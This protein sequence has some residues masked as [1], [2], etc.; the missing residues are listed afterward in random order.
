MGSLLRSV[1]GV[2]W[3]ELRDATGAAADG[4]PLLLSRIAYGDEDTARIAIDGLGDAI[5][6]L[7]FVVGEATAPTVPFLLELAG[8]PHVACR[9]E[10][11]SLLGRICRTAQW[12]SAAAATQ[13]RRHDASYRQQTGW[14]AASRTEEAIPARKLVPAWDETPAWHR[15][16]TG[17]GV[18][19]SPLD[20][21][22]PGWN[23]PLC[24]FPGK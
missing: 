15:S 7:G 20:K 10:V 19:I 8:S 16:V 22:F 24:G 13:D 5:C 9:A 23:S 11:L 14:E 4:I 12:H 18:R 1:S 2:R 6:A 3:A 21:G 17:R